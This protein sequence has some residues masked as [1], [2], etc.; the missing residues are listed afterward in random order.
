M[1]PSDD[2]LSVRMSRYLWAK[3]SGFP[4]TIDTVEVDEGVK[5]IER[6]P[7]TLILGDVDNLSSESWGRKSTVYLVIACQTA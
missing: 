3:L 5:V 7:A 4:A 2:G 6:S 1:E